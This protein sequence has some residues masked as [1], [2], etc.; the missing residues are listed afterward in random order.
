MEQHPL[1]QTKL[2]VPPIPPEPVPRPRLLAAWISAIAGIPDGTVLIIIDYPMDAT[3][4]LGNPFTGQVTRHLEYHADHSDMAALSLDGERGATASNDGPAVLRPAA[5]VSPS[6][7]AMIRPV[8]S[9]VK[10]D[11]RVY[12]GSRV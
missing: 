5:R 12:D 11:R 7:P 9:C 3:A 6:G 1:L 10:I 4:C 8:D 2:T